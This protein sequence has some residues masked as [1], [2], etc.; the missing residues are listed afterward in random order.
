MLRVKSLFR[1]VKE[2]LWQGIREN[3]T[4]WN[5]GGVEKQTPDSPRGKPRR[6]HRLFWGVGAWQ[7]Q[8]F[9]KVRG[10]WGGREPDST[11]RLLCVFFW[12]V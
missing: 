2:K 9:R 12:G 4:A 6:N 1:A 3:G 10:F 8:V 5:E 11:G 7:R